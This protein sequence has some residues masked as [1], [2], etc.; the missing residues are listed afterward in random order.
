MPSVTGTS[1]LSRARTLATQTAGDANVSQVIDNLA[2]ARA[3]L[4]SAIREVYRRK[5]KDQKFVN[6]ITV[7]NTVTISGGSGTCPDEIMREFLL[8]AN[9][10]DDND[11]LVTFLK[12]PTDAGSET[13]D[14]LGYCWLVG[15]NFKYKA[16]SPDLTSYSGNLFV[17]VPSYP[18]FPASMDDVIPFPSTATIDDVVAVLAM[19]LVGKESFE[20][21]SA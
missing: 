9:I 7:L 17:T 12:Y 14:Q 8:Q 1:I 10:T 20:V 13:Y 4:N 11:A 19:A 2:G 16:P 3:W 21:I 15:A 5:A 18:Q 6:D